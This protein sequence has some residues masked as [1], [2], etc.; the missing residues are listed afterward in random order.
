MYSFIHLSL[1]KKNIY[2]EL[3]NTKCGDTVPNVSQESPSGKQRGR[4]HLLAFYL[5]LFELL[6]PRNSPELL[7]YLRLR[8]LPQHQQ[9]GARVGAGG[10]WMG[11]LGLLE[12]LT[13]SNARHPDS[14][15]RS[16][17]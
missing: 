11:H 7:V 16:A 6:L 5:V 13:D 8:L 14:W 10:L 4:V 1:I 12:T 3:N 17:Q 2:C 9:G 15:H